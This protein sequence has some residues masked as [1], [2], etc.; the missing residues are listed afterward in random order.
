MSTTNKPSGVWRYLR[1]DRN[2]PAPEKIRDI[3]E[4]NS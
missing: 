1:K 3:R 2:E 4:D